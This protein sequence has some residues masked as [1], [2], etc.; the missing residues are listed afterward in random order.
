MG[1]LTNET[2]N[3]II[4]KAA[5]QRDGIYKCRGVSIELRIINRRTSQQQ[6]VNY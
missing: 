1:T 3:L 5:T 4:D 6:M 2:Q